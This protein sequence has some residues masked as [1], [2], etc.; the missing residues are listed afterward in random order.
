MPK[1]NTRRRI[2]A[3]QLSP[4]QEKRKCKKKGNQKSVWVWQC[5]ITPHASKKYH[6]QFLENVSLSALTKEPK[7]A[8]LSR[9]HRLFPC[10]ASC[11][12][13]KKRVKC[14]AGRPTHWLLSLQGKMQ[15]R[16][17][18][19]EAFQISFSLF[20]LFFPPYLGLDP[21]PCFLSFN[22]G[23]SRYENMFFTLQKNSGA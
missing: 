10:K 8:L 19:P 11:K 15:A 4:D 16:S 6:R 18:F 5:S 22:L 17:F 7:P 12:K 2:G 20:S 9:Q 14:K 3:H 21:L 13:R 1:Y 23:P